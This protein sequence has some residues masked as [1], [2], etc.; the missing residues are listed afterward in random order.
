MI[1]FLSTYEQRKKEINDFL[2]MMQFVET[3][4][5]QKDE[6]ENTEFDKFFHGESGSIMLTYQEMV[7]I[8]KSNILLMLYNI[9]EY[10]VANL[11]ESIYDEIVMNDLSYLDVNECI[12]SLWKK[13]ILKTANDPNANFN[14]FLKKNDLI[15]NGILEKRTLDLSVRKVLPAGNLDGQSI[16]ETFEAH[17]IIVKTSSSNYRPDILATIKK[18]RNDLA[19]GAVSFV[20]AD[21]EH[22][23]HDIEKY[24]NFVFSFL[25]ELIDDVSEYISQGKYRV[26]EDVV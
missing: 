23:L 5:F 15:I 1:S 4:Q 10:T 2:E 22:T 14:T 12:R 25:Q 11:M 19:H 3:K 21:R 9:I 18:Q 6:M 16:V 7:N 17:G 20:D 26:V 8:F 24:K 13:A